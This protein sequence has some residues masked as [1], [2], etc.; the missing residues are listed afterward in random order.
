[1]SNFVSESF[2]EYLNEGKKKPKSKEGKQKKFKKVM[3]EFGKGE[4]TPYNQNKSLRSK[5]QGG[6]KKE[7]A[8]AL[9]IAFNAAGIK[10]KKTHEEYIM[11]TS[12]ENFLN[13]NM[14]EDSEVIDINEIKEYIESCGFELEDSQKIYDEIQD[15]YISHGCRFKD[16]VSNAISIDGEFDPGTRGIPDKIIGPNYVIKEIDYKTIVLSYENDNKAMENNE[17]E[18]EY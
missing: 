4:L 1:M 7:R 2:D 6:T 16:L 12:I 13:E 15:T 8:Q 11:P 10:K 9:A 14:F 3:R 18:E 5:K 17:I